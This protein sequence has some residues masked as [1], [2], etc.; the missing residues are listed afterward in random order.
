LAIDPGFGTRVRYSGASLGYQ[1]ASVFAGGLAPLIA[2]AL[3]QASGYGAVAIYMMVM[4]AITIVATWLASETHK[5]DI[6][7]E[8]EAER[9]LAEARR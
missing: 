7:A 4:A 2:A 6:E 9:E 5:T 3:L 8:H 1:L